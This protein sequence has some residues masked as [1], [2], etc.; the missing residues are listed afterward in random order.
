[1]LGV[2]LVTF[3]RNVPWNNELDALAP[4]S[5]AEYWRGYL[6]RWTAWNHMRTLAATAAS[7]AFVTA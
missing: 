2:L 1:M 6:R 5:A 4:E 7:A 3:A